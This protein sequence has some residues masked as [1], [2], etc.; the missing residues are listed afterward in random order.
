MTEKNQK[1]ISI[2]KMAKMNQTSISTLRLYDS[3]Y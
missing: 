3:M 1:Y 2:G